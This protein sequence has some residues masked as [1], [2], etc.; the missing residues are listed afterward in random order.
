VVDDELLEPTTFFLNYQV[1]RNIWHLLASQMSRLI[2]VLP[3][4]N[5]HAWD[6]LNN[7]LP[8]VHTPWSTQISVV[9]VEDVIAALCSDITGGLRDH[10]DRLKAKYIPKGIVTPST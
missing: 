6:A 9:S 8:K 4:A 1:L 7:V 10:A 3:R 5:A 2:F